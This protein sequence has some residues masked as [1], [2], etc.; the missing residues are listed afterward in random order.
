MSFRKN[1]SEEE[2]PQTWKIFS[3]QVLPSKRLFFEYSDTR[4]SRKKLDDQFKKNCL[5]Y[6]IYCFEKSTKDENFNISAQ[7][8]RNNYNEIFSVKVNSFRNQFLLWKWKEWINVIWENLNSIFLY[9]YIIPW[10]M[11]L[12]YIRISSNLRWHV[13]RSVSPSGNYQTN[14]YEVCSALFPMLS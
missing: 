14:N 13:Y 9:S 11:F 2:P 1:T 7:L 3:N 4:K 5:L 8:N 12:F 6:L 10:T